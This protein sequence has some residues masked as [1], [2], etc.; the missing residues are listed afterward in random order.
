MATA[1]TFDLGPRLAATAGQ[2]RDPRAVRARLAMLEHVLEG[3]VRLP[4]N[5]RLGLDAALGF[6]PVAGDLLSALIG[7]YLVWEAR[8]A[9]LSRWACTRLL[10]R[11]G[12]DAAIGAVPV[13]GDLFDIVYRSNSRNVRRI[14]AHI[15]R[16]GAGPVIKGQVVKG[17]VV[18]GRL[19]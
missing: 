5:Q 2:R 16:H 7:V 11:V 14:L 6:V 10:G 15:D 1:L 13:A 4:G 9:G 19:A 3:L 8:N 12:L 18:E 17:Q